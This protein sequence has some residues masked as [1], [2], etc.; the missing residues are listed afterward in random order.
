MKN[1]AN[2]KGD[3]IIHYISTTNKQHVFT[4]ILNEQKSRK[5]KLGHLT[6]EFSN[7]KKKHIFDFRKKNKQQNKSFA[8]INRERDLQ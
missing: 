2:R 4:Y 1:K 7:A 3:G 5:R 6:M 8:D